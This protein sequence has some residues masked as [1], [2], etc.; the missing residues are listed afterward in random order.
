LLGVK[1]LG[2]GFNGGGFLYSKL[3]LWIM[4][5][6]RLFTQGAAVAVILGL[7]FKKY[8]HLKLIKL[9]YVLPVYILDLVFSEYYLVSIY[10]N[11]IN[12]LVFVC[13][14]I[15]CISA[16]VL[17]LLTYFEIKT[18]KIKFSKECKKNTV[19][20]IL[21][22]IFLGAY[23]C[24]VQNLIGN[25][26]GNFGLLTTAHYAFIACPVI[27]FIIVTLLLKNKN[28]DDRYYALFALT[29]GLFI[30]HWHLYY[31]GKI[32][33]I[34]LSLCHFGICIMMLSMIL[35]NRYLAVF[36]LVNSTIGAIITL[37]M[38]FGIGDNIFTYY[39]SMHFVIDHTWLL[40]LPYLY[41]KYEIFDQVKIKDVVK[42]IPFNTVYFI[43]AAI[44]QFIVGLTSWG[45]VSYLFLNDETITNLLAV[46]KPIKDN[47]TF[48]VTV[49]GYTST[50]YYLY[51]IIVYVG[52]NLVSFAG[53]GLYKL[54]F[55]GKK[56]VK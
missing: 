44:G 28:K 27:C 47:F 1:D 53:F 48:S 42:L 9:V 51:W 19:L 49:N 32:D 14:F 17:C 52:L 21:A 8:D 25:Q 18:E 39:G 50:V 12:Y 29:L 40:I 2:S 6:I 30:K 22:F 37:A 38:P 43:A 54:L 5:F 56:K 36:A 15:E 26:V 55:I 4:F 23:N 24:T 7:F 34:P 16:I 33:G 20:A 11:S 3:V 46:L 10:G 41:F 31:F 45:W 13:Y 35:K